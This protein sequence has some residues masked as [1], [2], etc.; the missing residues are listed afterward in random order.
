MKNKV[1]IVGSGET[2]DID[3]AKFNKIYSANVAFKRLDSFK[4]VVYV[5]SEALL[6]TEKDLTEARPFE[7]FSVSESNQ[8]RIDK[9]QQID[10]ISAKKIYVVCNDSNRV[11]SALRRKNIKYEILEI[12]NSAKL[13]SLF[14]NCFSIKQIIYFFLKLPSLKLKL[15]FIFQY[16]MKQK[17]S[18]FFRPS[19]GITSIMIAI[20]E[21]SDSCI[22]S[23]GI[24]VSNQEK[25]R[26]AFWGG[27]SV[28]Y[29]DECHGMDN[30]YYEF[31]K[32]RGITNL[33]LTNES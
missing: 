12:I 5:L 25:N 3:S 23:N 26:T 6:Y 14:T 30:L 32:S 24:N 10:G 9:Y 17:M 27:V 28:Q 31:F 22:F 13:W 15:S 4:K 18:V 29:P 16:T 11:R 7:G 1:L 8:M 2:S 20:N 19:T 33:F 21:N